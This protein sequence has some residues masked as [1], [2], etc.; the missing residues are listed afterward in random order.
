M[1]VASFTPAHTKFSA[2]LR[3]DQTGSRVT[4]NKDDFTDPYK[5]STSCCKLK[6]RW[7]ILTSRNAEKN[8]NQLEKQEESFLSF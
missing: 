3:K 1:R 7:F 2:K 8:S 4:D 5:H 6:L